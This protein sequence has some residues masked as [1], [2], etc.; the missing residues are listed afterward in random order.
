[1]RPISTIDKLVSSS[2]FKKLLPYLNKAKSIEVVNN[3][4][5]L[6]DY[7]IERII[8]DSYNECPEQWA[9]PQ[10]LRERMVLFLTDS[11]RISQIKYIMWSLF[12]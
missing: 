11:S 6:Q 5:S 7:E 9:I 10:N 8:Y 12:K 4:L 3:F 2:F 1:M